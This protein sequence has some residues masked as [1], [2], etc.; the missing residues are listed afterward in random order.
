MHPDED[1]AEVQ[2][3]DLRKISAAGSPSGT[4]AN[5]D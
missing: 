3:I 5:E 2:R 4:T 1:N